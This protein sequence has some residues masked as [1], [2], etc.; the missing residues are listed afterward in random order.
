MLS[1]K[2]KIQFDAEYTVVVGIEKVLSGLLI[3]RNKKI[4]RERTKRQN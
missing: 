3:E 4:P 2:T 1:S